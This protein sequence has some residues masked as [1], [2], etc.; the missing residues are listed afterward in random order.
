MIVTWNQVLFYPAGES[1]D[2]LTY[3]ASLKLPA[4]WKYDTALPVESGGGSEIRFAPV[5]LTKLVDSPVLAGEYF[6]RV[7]LTPG[8][9]P[10]MYL[11]MASDSKAALAMPDSEVAAYRHLAA[12]ALSLFGAWHFKEYR[13]LVPM[14]DHISHFG[15]EHHESSEDRVVERTWLDDDIRISN[16]NLMPHELTHSWNG[17]IA[18][19]PEASPLR[20]TG[21]Q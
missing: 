16:T 21:S 6:R 20:T 17:S 10:H 4:G 2:G 14:S 7:D 3:A 8:T 1:S 11:C 5:S 15:L 12:E 13:L 19:P 9:T 18:A